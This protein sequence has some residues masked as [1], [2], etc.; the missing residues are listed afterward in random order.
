M[1]CCNTDKFEANNSIGKLNIEE[2]SNIWRKNAQRH[3]PAKT[4]L[5]VYGNLARK[6]R[7]YAFDIRFYCGNCASKLPVHNATSKSEI[8]DTETRCNCCGTYNKIV[9]PRCKICNK[10]VGL[11][12]HYQL[13]GTEA[14]A[15]QKTFIVKDATKFRSFMDIIGVFATGGH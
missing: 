3:I 11:C 14:I 15:L 10:L 4:I 7:L 12:N 9:I 5:E 13:Y 1:S 8:D 6:C 2:Q